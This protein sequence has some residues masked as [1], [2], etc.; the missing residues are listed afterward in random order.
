VIFGFPLALILAW[1]FELTPEGLKRETAVDPAESIT[2]VT[3]RKLDFAII[4]LLAVALIFVVVDNYV[5]EAEPEQAEVTAES[6]SAPEDDPVLAL[7]TGPTVAVLP[8]TNLSGDPEQEYFSDGLTDDIITALSRFRELFVI[9][10]NSTFRYKG[11]SVDVREL[12]RDLGARYVVEGSVRKA[13]TRL[14]V[15]VQLLDARDGTHLWADTYDRDLSA[16][17]I[18]AVQDEITEQVVGTIAS[19]SGV[20]SRA[21]FAE[22][23]EKPTDSL[24]AY[25]CVLQGGAYYRDNYGQATEHVKVRACLERAVKSDPGY[26]DAWANLSLIYLDEYRFNYNPRPNPLVRALEAAHRAVDSDP[27]HQGAHQALALSYFFRHE[28]DG[29]FAETERAIALNPNNAATLALL[30]AMLNFVG[31]PRG[32]LLVRKAVKLDPFHSTWFNFAIAHYHFDKGEYEEALAAA[33]KINIPGYFWPQIY[34]A[35]IYGE[36]GRQSEARSALEELLRLYPGFTTEKLIEE[37]QK[38]N[39]GDD[40]I[41][42]WVAALRK[43]GLP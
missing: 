5:L 35:A 25:E 20:I 14:R 30:G 9:A 42:R 40:T 29:F 31:D 10:R 19:N 26:A 1:A 4:G 28:L 34:L 11:K 15:T 37:L 13:G 17:D 33:R 7:P 12:N 43:A 22:I 23:K 16:S 3:G 8:F 18:F 6:V 27:T 2:H 21:R 36:L 39:R 32:I 38:T 41:R 24:D